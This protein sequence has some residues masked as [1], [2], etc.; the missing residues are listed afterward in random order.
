M[1]NKINEQLSLDVGDAVKKTRPKN[2]PAIKNTDASASAFGWRFQII[3]GIILSIHNIKEI[4]FVEIEGSTE[5]IELYFSDKD[6]AY[7]QSKAIQGN[8]FDKTDVAAT[9]ATMAMNT[10]INTSNRTE[11]KY[12]ELMYVVNFRN[13]LNLNN[14]D[15]IASWNP[16]LK[17]PF[18]RKYNSLP[19]KAKKF[20]RARIKTAKKQLEEKYIGSIQYFDLNRLKL[21]TILFSS[22]EQDEVNYLSLEN[23]IEDLFEKLKLNIRLGKIHVIRDMLITKY[24]AN[25]GSKEWGEKHKR[26]SKENLIWKIIFGIIDSAPTE[27]YEELPIGIEGELDIYEHDFVEQQVE[28]VVIINKV[29][30][31]FNEYMKLEN[32][33]NRKE[34][35]RRF[36]NH[37]LSDY[38]DIF[39]LNEDPIVQEYGI[40]MIITR[41]IYGQRTIAK[42]KDGVN[43]K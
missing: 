31:G 15:L 42:I 27:F 40:K 18:I 19:S 21:A 11:G 36:V 34:V 25:A 41:I 14:A 13:P 4:K 30:A 7:I 6:P 32:E 1:D 37:K 28:D 3:A 8:I 24:L 35:F 38:K 16:D 9:K 12:S 29:L 33:R 2:V 20:I 5:D 10:L 22:D 23:V 43:L 26:I 17:R 39:P